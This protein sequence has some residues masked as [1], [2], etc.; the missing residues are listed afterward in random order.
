M[1]VQSLYNTSA[2]LGD[3]ETGIC[4]NSFEVTQLDNTQEVLLFDATGG[5][6]LQSP[7]AFLAGARGTWGAQ[8]NTV[9]SRLPLQMPF[10][11]N[12]MKVVHFSGD[13][14]SDSNFTIRV[15]R[16]DIDGQLDKEIL[17]IALGNDPENPNA[18]ILDFY[19][20]NWLVDAFFGVSFQTT[21]ELTF[22][23]SFDIGLIK[24]KLETVNPAR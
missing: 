10:I 8:T 21:I 20:L 17:P 3:K 23:V 9:L 15:Y 12:H 1:E 13:E 18:Y 19:G 5:I 22:G 4:R 24:N 14:I 11:I 16:L 2:L 6:R 7:A